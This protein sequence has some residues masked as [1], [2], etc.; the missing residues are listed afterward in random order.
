MPPVAKIPPQ[1]NSPKTTALLS[2][3]LLLEGGTK[4]VGVF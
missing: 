1:S 2:A 3:S 4:F